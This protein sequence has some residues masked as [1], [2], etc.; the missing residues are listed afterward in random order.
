MNVAGASRPCVSPGI[1]GRDARATFSTVA[2][3]SEK[4]RSF[5]EQKATV[6]SVAWAS[7]PCV[8]PR[9][10]GR[11]ARATGC[12]NRLLIPS[13]HTLRVSPVFNHPAGETAKRV[14]LWFSDGCAYAVWS[15]IFRE[16]QSRE[17]V[18]RR[19]SWNEIAIRS[20]CSTL[21]VSKV[22]LS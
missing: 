8:F 4:G 1:H 21:S 2:F 7:C 20:A 13:L 9:N 18:K 12:F 22:S 14:A 3:F 19:G 16:D 10:H 15:R 5:A 11:D 6:N 17:V